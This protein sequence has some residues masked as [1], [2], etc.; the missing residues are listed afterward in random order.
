MDHQPPTVELLEARHSFPCPFTSKVI[1]A[2]GT[3][4]PARA[5]ACV[6]GS[7]GLDSPPP[8]SVKTASGGRHESVTLEPVCP[9]AQS[10]IDLYAALRKLEGVMFL[11]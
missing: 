2:T 8:S 10:V 6:Q 1:G 5:S 4:L 7:L 11:F 3:D 9:D